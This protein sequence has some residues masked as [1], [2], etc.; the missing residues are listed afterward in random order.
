MTGAVRA[1]LIAAVLSG[2]PSTAHALATGRDPLLAT[3]AAGTLVPGRV[4][5]PLAGLIAHTVLSTGWTTVL[6]ALARRH[7]LGVGGGAAAGVLIAALDLGVVGRRYPAIRALP[8]L[9]QWLDH[10]VFGAV[11]GALLDQPPRVAR[12]RRYSS[13]ASG[14][15]SERGRRGGVPLTGR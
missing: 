13:R 1:G 15:P 5:D 4:P 3:R 14:F 9:P 12:W 11:L 2:A 7:R 8:A 10:V 6:A